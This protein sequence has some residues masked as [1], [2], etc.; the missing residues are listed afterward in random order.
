MPDNSNDLSGVL[1]LLF[2]N[3]FFI[4]RTHRCKC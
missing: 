3:G 4:V 1:P 2:Q